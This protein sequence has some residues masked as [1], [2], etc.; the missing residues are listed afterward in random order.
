[1][2]RTAGATV[3]DVSALWEQVRSASWLLRVALILFVLL[4]LLGPPELRSAVPIWFPFLIALGL[5][6]LFFAEAQ[7]GGGR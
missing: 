2:E 7:R 3:V 4:W 5:E 6:V 1:M